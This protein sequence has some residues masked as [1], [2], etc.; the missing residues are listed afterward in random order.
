MKISSRTWSWVLGEAAEDVGG[1]DLGFGR[2]R[3]ADAHPHAPE[4][5]VAE[6]AL[7]ALQAV[8]A[9][10]APAL[11]GLHLPNGRSIS[12]WTAISRSSGTRRS[13]RAGPAESPDSFM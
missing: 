2:V 10:H 5:A 13:P 12:S 1:D 11:L 8:V 3:A 6:P 4:L 9:G 7:E